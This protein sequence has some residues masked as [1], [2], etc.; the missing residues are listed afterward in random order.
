MDAQ[1]TVISTH[2]LTK[3]YGKKT[4]LESVDLEI[5]KGRL[6]GLIGSEGAGKTT[7]LRI[8]AGFI[9]S[10]KGEI[11]ILG[12]TGRGGLRRAQRSIGAF[13]DVPACY[14]EL[15]V[16][17]NLKMRGILVGKK[18]N[19]RRLEL[20][21]KFLLKNKHVGKRGLRSASLGVKQVTGI[22]AAMIGDPQILLF[23]EP[24]YGL[25]TD[26]LV[27]ARDEFTKLYSEKGVTILA[28]AHDPAELDD[29]AT[30]YIFMSGG[31]LLEQISADALG[32]KMAELGLESVGE[33]YVS[34]TA[35]ETGK[36]GA[37]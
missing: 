14:D 27:A 19:E 31:R 28:S 1:E 24:L 33:Y 2:G 6:Y 12:R 17:D 16:G 29:L 11:E 22:V 35:A 18:D 32:E 25:D 5:K 30:D 13:I 36:G 34:L 4:A 8:L 7:L 21:E 37:K 10:Y 20:R 26:G 23:D 9:P 15:S 3:R